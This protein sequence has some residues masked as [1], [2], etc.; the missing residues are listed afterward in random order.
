MKNLKRIIP[1]ALV[2]CLCLTALAGCRKRTEPAPQ[3]TPSPQ[4]TA[5]PTT[6]NTMG[7]ITY[8][9]DSYIAVTEYTADRKKNYW[10]EMGIS[11]DADNIHANLQQSGVSPQSVRKSAVPKRS[12]F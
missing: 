12:G 5:S 10:I 4:A 3:V 8:V 6:K 2:L 11:Y 9:G 7:L 1:A